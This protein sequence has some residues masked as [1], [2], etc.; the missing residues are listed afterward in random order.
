MV[1]LQLGVHSSRAILVPTTPMDPPV[2][3][4]LDPSGPFL[5]QA[6]CHG[7]LGQRIRAW[8]EIDPV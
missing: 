1:P 7:G 8:D 6:T 4:A 2:G 3:P 5:L